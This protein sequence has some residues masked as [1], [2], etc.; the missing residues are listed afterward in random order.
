MTL[1]W[2]PNAEPDLGGYIIYY[3]PASRVYT[4]AVNVGNV[5]NYTVRGLVTNAFYFFA[6][7]A[8]STN[9]LESDFSDEVCF[10]NAATNANSGPRVYAGEPQT[11]RLPAVA[12]LAGAVEDDGLPD[13]PG[14][15]TNLWS[16]VSGPGAVTFAN[17]LSTNTAASFSAAGG[18]VLRLTAGDGQFVASSAVNVAVLPPAGLAPPAPDSVQVRITRL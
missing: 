3:G 10:F 4:N 6:A 12:V 13:P 16:K 14:R 5:T 15:V 1:A 7:T 11:V 9:G 17:A 8:Y 2:D 18:Y